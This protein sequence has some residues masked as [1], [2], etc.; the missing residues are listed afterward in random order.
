ME[1]LETEYTSAQ[2]RAQEVLDGKLMKLSKNQH[3]S[4]IYMTLEVIMSGC[5]SRIRSWQQILVM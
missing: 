4:Q 3:T 5:Q 2:N 1:Q